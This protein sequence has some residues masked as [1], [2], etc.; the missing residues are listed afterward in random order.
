MPCRRYCGETTRHPS[1]AEVCEYRLVRVR[2]RVRVR[3]RVRVRVRVRVRSRDE[4][5]E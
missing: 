2:V 3:I 1:S 4:V 5:A